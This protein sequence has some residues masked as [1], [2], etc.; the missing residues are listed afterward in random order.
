MLIRGWQVHA[1]QEAGLNPYAYGWDRS[2]RAAELQERYANLAAGEEATGDAD[3]VGVAGRV[4]ARRVFGK[5]AFLTIRDESST[6]QVS[7]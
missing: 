2:H 1:L 5:L 7:C 3:R 4:V 6:I